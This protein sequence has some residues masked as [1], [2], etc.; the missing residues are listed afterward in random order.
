VRHTVRIDGGTPPCY[1]RSRKVENRENKQGGE[2]CAYI[3]SDGKDVVV[4]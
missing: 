2:S 4:L 3:Q 1:T